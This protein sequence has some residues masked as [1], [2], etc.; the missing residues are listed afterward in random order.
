MCMGVP[1]NLQMSTGQLTVVKLALVT[2][3]LGGCTV[4]VS[5]YTLNSTQWSDDEQDVK[6]RAAFDLQCGEGSLVLEVLATNNG[7]D[8]SPFTRAT[9]VGV[10]GCGRRAAYVLTD[11]GFVLNSSNRALP[12]SPANSAPPQGA[13]KPD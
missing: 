9:Q 11:R 2:L 1:D 3:L 4:M 12:D 8:G 5:G 6:R 10:T 13:G 7:N